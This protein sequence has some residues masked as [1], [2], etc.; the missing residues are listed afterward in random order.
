[1]SEFHHQISVNLHALHDWHVEA[2]TLK[3]HDCPWS[4][5]DRLGVDFR[6][7]WS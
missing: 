1:M 3:W 4:P 7:G 2:H 5:C 6:K